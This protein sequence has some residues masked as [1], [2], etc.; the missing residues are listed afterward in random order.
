MAIH[1]LVRDTHAQNHYRVV[2]QLSLQSKRDTQ[3]SLCRRPNPTMNPS[4]LFV[5]EHH[6]QQVAHRYK[7]DRESLS[8]T[9]V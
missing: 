7:Y 6:P 8:P 2:G 1:H 5:F 4:D 3:E 9:V